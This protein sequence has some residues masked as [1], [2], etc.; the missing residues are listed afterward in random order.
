M[1]EPER[2]Y[3]RIEAKDRLRCSLAT[4]EKLIRQGDLPVVRMGRKILIRESAIQRWIE[5]HEQLDGR[6]KDSE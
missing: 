5:T 1:G 4:L 6:Q 2:L 3:T